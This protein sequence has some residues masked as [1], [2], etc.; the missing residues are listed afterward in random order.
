MAVPPLFTRAIELADSVHA[1]AD[2]RGLDRFQRRAA[3]ELLGRV[4][5][6]GEPSFGVAL[7]RVSQQMDN[8]ADL[9]ALAITYAREEAAGRSAV[10][11][12]KPATQ[13]SMRWDTEE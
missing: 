11:G 7:Y 8:A 12:T 10:T 3:L 13:E 6:S 5:G 9:E 4:I 1:M 2:E